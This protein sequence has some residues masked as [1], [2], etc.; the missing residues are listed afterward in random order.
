MIFLVIKTINSKRQTTKK[1]ME[2]EGEGEK[3][4]REGKK[5]RRG[6]GRK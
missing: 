5:K 3:E 6:G 1:T 2:E 4:G